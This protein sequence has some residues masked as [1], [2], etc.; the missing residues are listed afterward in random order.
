MYHFACRECRSLILVLT[1]LDV[2][3]CLENH[4][5]IQTCPWAIELFFG[6]DRGLQRTRTVSRMC[7]IGSLNSAGMPRAH[8]ILP[9][10][11]TEKTI[12]FVHGRDVS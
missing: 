5:R 6:Q 7:M 2:R 8:S 9:V 4:V 11:T 10:G 12:R 3:L 1:R